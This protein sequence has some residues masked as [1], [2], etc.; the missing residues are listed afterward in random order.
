MVQAV[1][2]TL[3]VDPRRGVDEPSG[4]PNL[5]YKT[6]TA[7]LVAAQG[8]ALIRLAI[9]T[10]S[11]ASGERFPLMVAEQVIV[12]GQEATQGEGV[13]ITGG[14]AVPGDGA[15]AAAVIMEGQ[16]QLRGITVQN[17][18]GVGILVRGGTPLVRACRVMQGSQAGLHIGGTARPLVISTRVEAIAGAGLRLTA[19]AKGEIRT[20]TLQRCQVG[21]Q[22]S[23]AAAPLLVDNQCST[24][25][26]GMQISG[27]ASP[28]LRRNR[29]VQN[30]QWGL[31]VVERARPDLGQPTDEGGNILRYNGQADLRN[32]TGQTLTTVG[33]DLLPQRLVGAVN[34]APSQQPDPAAVPT[35]LLNQ[36]IQA[37]PTPVP[38]TPAPPTA[39]GPA[40]LPPSRFVDLQGHWATPYIEALA[41]RNLI[42]GFED[43]TYRP[44]DTI[45]RAQFAALVAASYGAISMIRPA[46]SF[47][48]VPPTFWAYG[49]IDLAQRRGFVGG[50]PDQTYRPNQP[51][52]RVQAMV[53]VANGLALPAAPASGLGVYDDRAQ[54]PSYA[55]NAL[56][57]A[58]QAGLIINHPDPSQLRPQEPMT[59]A[60]VAALIYQGL[61]TLGQAPSLA[62]AADVVQPQ[63]VQGSFP[64]IQTHWARDFIQGLLNANLLRGQDDGRFYPDQPMPRAQFAA[65]ISSAFNPSPRRSAV[66][67]WDVPAQYWAAGAIQTAHRAG[68]LS[69]FPDGSFAPDNAILRVQVWVALV[70]GLGLLANQ[71][72]DAKG[73]SRFRDRATLPSYALDAVAK[74]ARLGLIINL[75][76]AG[77]LHPNRVASRADVVAAVYQTLAL[78]NRVPALNNPYIVRP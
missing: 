52:T 19:Q 33:N 35:L 76:D 65:L 54:I 74:A 8:S 63:M 6:L 53:A 30:Q 1:A 39:P 37:S 47:V 41:D 32:D 25:Q 69:G 68:F 48:D 73:L 14:G 43:G 60:E 78:Q 26:T 21:I 67:F 15:M 22:L 71:T 40:P 23:D 58:T 77:L 38:P 55:I 42:K 45:N 10:Y 31:L 2:K 28:V 11:A 64:D 72:V 46:L 61:V 36:P 20:C 29:L 49:A 59:R 16:G 56:A 66:Q 17:P 62:L 3:E 18:Q 9:G 44:D 50:Y 13:I 51:M 7:A 5:P 75:P 27:T 4:R 70:N 12:I 57:A 24:N 34:L